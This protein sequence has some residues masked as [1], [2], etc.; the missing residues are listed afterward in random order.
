MSSLSPCRKKQSDP[1]VNVVTKVSRSNSK[2]NDVVRKMKGK[3]VNVEERATGTVEWMVY[4][5]Y[6]IALGGLCVVLFILMMYI[7]DQGM[8]VGL[9]WWLSVW[10]EAKDNSKYFKRIKKIYLFD[11]F[12]WIHLINQTDFSFFFYLFFVGIVF[13]IIV[14]PGVSFMSLYML[15][16]V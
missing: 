2:E 8:S 11:Y 16:C 6:M 7:A 13:L 15:S 10:S 5:S 4:R 12:L 9:Q 1:N 3:L 14:L